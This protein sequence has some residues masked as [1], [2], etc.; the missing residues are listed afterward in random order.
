M[1]SKILQLTVGSR[2]LSQAEKKILLLQAEQI[3]KIHSKWSW[4]EKKLSFCELLSLF[5]HLLFSQLEINHVIQ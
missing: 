2:D 3:H 1:S 5:Q 4:V